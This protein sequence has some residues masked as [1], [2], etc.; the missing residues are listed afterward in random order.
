MASK[1]NC[2][3]NGI[4]YYRIRKTYGKK[5]NK[6]G[7]LVD[8]VI[9][10]YGSNKTDAENRAKEYEKNHSC[11]VDVND[12]L[13]VVLD[14]YV[15]QVFMNGKHSDGTKVRYETSYRLRIKGS[16][17]GEYKTCEVNGKVIQNFFND[18]M[19]KK[20]SYSNLVAT[21]NLLS[22]F[23]AYAAIEGY[24]INP[25]GNISLPREN[26]GDDDEGEIVVFNDDEINKIINCKK[27]GNNAINRFLFI[28]ALGTG[29][30][31]GE[32]LGLRYKNIKDGKILVTKQATTDINGKRKTGRTKSR[33]SVR[34]VPVPKWILKEFEARIGGPDD[35]VFP[36]MNGNIMDATNLDRS[37]KRFL[38]SIGVP[39]KSFHTLRKTYCTM[40]A[41]RGV[42]LQ[43]ASI[44]MG[45]ANINTT[46]R[47]YT[48]ISDQQKKS[49]IEKIDDLFSPEILEE[50]KQKM[51][52][53]IEHLPQ[54]AS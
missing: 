19:E 47:Y 16:K 49:A 23:F 7:K 9:P 36:S 20:T 45:H 24:C 43:V 12:N 27:T 22:L 38:K 1:T 29:L 25:M 10:F 52:Q 46:A 41:E 8:N 30:R 28:F 18:M 33:R 37:F 39:Y 51:I 40:L 50:P 42:P 34:Y 53:V 6:A 3:I 44:L 11:N 48:F 15:Y 4:K 17:L 26:D 31:Q 2:E 35:L 54:P 14:Y 21:R 13:L 5:L 32:L